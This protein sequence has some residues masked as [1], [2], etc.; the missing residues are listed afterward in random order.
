MNL[1][2]PISGTIRNPDVERHFMVMHKLVGKATAKL[3]GLVLAESDDVLVVRETGKK[4]YPP[5]LYFPESSIAPDSLKTIDR[6]T[7]CP[8]KGEATYFDVA[9]A[10]VPAPAAAWRYDST[11][12]FHEDIKLLR[13]RVSFDTNMVQL[14]VSDE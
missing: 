1:S 8:I 13:G 9:G 11:L 14:T 7:F 3:G 10:D 12:D 6:K 5:R 4:E 2:E